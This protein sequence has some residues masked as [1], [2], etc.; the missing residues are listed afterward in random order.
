MTLH[1]LS[2]RAFFHTPRQMMYCVLYF[3]FLDDTNKDV[4][5]AVERGVRATSAFKEADP[6]LLERKCSL[7]CS[8]KYPYPGFFGLSP[9]TC[10]PLKI[11]V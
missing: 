5:E 10:T 6:V 7:R 3:S 4:S 8:R 11:P 2:L 1:Q 9:P